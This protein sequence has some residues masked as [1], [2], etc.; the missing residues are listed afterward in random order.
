M[1]GS[2]AVLGKNTTNKI[3]HAKTLMSN[4]TSIRQAFG[5]HMK[6]IGASGL[7]LRASVLSGW[8]YPRPK[9]RKLAWNMTVGTDIHNATGMIQTCKFSCGAVLKSSP[10]HKTFLQQQNHP[11]CGHVCVKDSR[12]VS[13]S[14]QEE[15]NDPLKATWDQNLDLSVCGGGVYKD[16]SGRGWLKMSKWLSG[17][18]CLSKTTRL[19]SP[20]LALQYQS[21]RHYARRRRQGDKGECSEED[22]EEKKRQLRG[23]VMYV[24]N[25]MNW[26]R[27]CWNIGKLRRKV[28]PTF[29]ESEFLGGAKQAVSY[30]TQM[31]SEGKFDRLSGLVVMEVIDWLK[32]FRNS[33]A[34]KEQEAL[35]L[36]PDD[37]ALIKIRYL[38]LEFEQDEVLAFVDTVCFGL[39]LCDNVPYFVDLGIRFKRDYSPDPPSDWVVAGVSHIRLQNLAGN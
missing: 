38:H 16:A 17:A 12:S 31:V 39:K 1:A 15:N 2:S 26:F 8:P 19:A 35:A 27:K 4:K 22:E 7:C 36:S 33:L 20:K 32:D 6:W 3:I 14:F 23:A 10:Q 18:Y 5:I 37:I 11:F 9:K 34:A 21:V 25:P 13:S 28:D 30:V 29:S 24:S